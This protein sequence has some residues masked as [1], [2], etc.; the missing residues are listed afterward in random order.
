MVVADVRVLGDHDPTLFPYG[1]E[2]AEP[3]VAALAQESDCLTARN[4]RSKPP[5]PRRIIAL[6]VRVVGEDFLYR[7]PAANRTRTIWT[8]YR[9]Q[10]IPDVPWPTIA[11]NSAAKEYLAVNLKCSSLTAG[12]L[13]AP[14]IA[15]DTIEG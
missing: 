14:A 3:V 7:H 4:Q 9:S 13:A 10:Q 1:S 12:I 2:E 15:A 11:T 6:A 5:K 8:G